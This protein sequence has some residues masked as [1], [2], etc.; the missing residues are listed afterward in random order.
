MFLPVGVSHCPMDDVQLPELIG[1][2][3][4]SPV[5]KY[6]I[7]V[8]E[9]SV[10]LVRTKKSRRDQGPPHLFKKLK[11]VSYTDLTEREKN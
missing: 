9:M 7:A 1:D 10:P 11:M 6:Y 4:K 3:L 5:C 2:C 8:A